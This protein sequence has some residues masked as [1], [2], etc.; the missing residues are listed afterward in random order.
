[1]IRHASEMR[2]TL[3]MPGERG[4][5]DGVDG[6]GCIRS[7][8]AAGC[9]KI[10]DAITGTAGPSGVLGVCGVIANP[11]RKR[12]G[13]GERLAALGRVQDLPSDSKQAYAVAQCEG[14]IG[15]LRGFHRT[16][17]IHPVLGRRRMATIEPRVIAV[18][19]VF[20]DGASVGSQWSVYRTMPC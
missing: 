1:M 14:I 8:F 18:S 11:A 20:P 10:M 15:D 16:P 3:R 9:G 13:L 2:A 7:N 5:E 19:H 17:Q 6:A 4:K 12:A